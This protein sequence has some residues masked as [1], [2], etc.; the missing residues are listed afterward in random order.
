MEPATPEATLDYREVGVPEFDNNPLLAH[1]R[2][3]PEKDTDA[4]V[5]LGI[6][7]KFD[8]NE[9]DLPTSVRRIRVSRLRQF[10]IP[11]LPVHRRALINISSQMF[12]SYSA[13]NPMTPE[14]QAILY[15]GP[16]NAPYRSTISFVAGHSGMGKSTLMDRILA[17]LGNQ[18]CQHQTF[19]DKEFPEK[20][21][22]WLRRNL[23]EHCTLGTL[24]ATF[25]D[26]TDRV[27]GTNLYSGAFTKVRADRSQYL[28]QIRKIITDHHVGMLVLD[29]FQNLSLMGV[30]AKK[31]IALLVNLRDELGLPIVLVGTYKALRLLE[32]NMSSA[33]R[34]CEGG[35]FDLAR[36]PSAGDEAWNLFCEAAW[37][38]MWVRK[39][40]EFGTEITDAL[41]ELSQGISGIMLSVLA[42]AQLAAMEDD[43]AEKVDADLIRKVYQERMTPLHPAIRIL[44]SGD[45][46]LMEGFDDLYRNAY[47]SG[48]RSEDDIGTDQR[49]SDGENSLA[50]ATQSSTEPQ[51]TESQ[52]KSGRRTR[53]TSARTPGMTKEQIETLGKAE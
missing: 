48:D 33:R 47:P 46:N 28:K 13:R 27:L 1:L 15:G 35:Y 50:S 37:N 49:P 31:I 42:T 51:N 14:G 26:H 12:D 25:G 11:V 29:E 39:P 6:G 8:P 19:K 22:L 23:P 3:P 52:S 10:F 21:I 18:V 44:K 2:L 17:S 36:P 40:A 43:G 45:Q 7:A 38:Y 41:Y 9:R 24:C 30:G 32:G 20:Q 16:T 4:F 34:L 5:A 53:K